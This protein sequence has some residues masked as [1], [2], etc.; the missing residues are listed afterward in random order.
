MLAT[1]NCGP[2]LLG[3]A[4]YIRLKGMT[5]LS[6]PIIKCE[7]VLSVGNYFRLQEGNGILKGG[8]GFRKV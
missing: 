5:L 7:P 6:R 8:P 3:V 1:I 4:H 2:P